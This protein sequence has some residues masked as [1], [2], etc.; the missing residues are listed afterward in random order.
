MGSNTNI[1]RLGSDVWR[2]VL[3]WLCWKDLIKVSHLC[4]FLHGIANT[5]QLWEGDV[6]ALL[7]TIGRDVEIQPNTKKQFIHLATSFQ[8]NKSNPEAVKIIDNG[9]SVEYRVW[10]RDD[11]CYIPSLL[12]MLDE[13]Q[14][15]AKFRISSKSRVPDELNFGF[16]AINGMMSGCSCQ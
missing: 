1:E 7:A 15:V 13:G 5:D 10:A 9:K 8:Y 6:K 4:S 12:A 16:G 3:K 11:H 2:N 14:I